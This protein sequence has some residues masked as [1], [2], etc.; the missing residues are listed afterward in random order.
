METSETVS[1]SSYGTPTSYP[2]HKNELTTYE[3][4]WYYDSNL[5]IPSNITMFSIGIGFMLLSFLSLLFKDAEDARKWRMFW[6]NGQFFLTVIFT[7]VLLWSRF[8]HLLSYEDYYTL[9]TTEDGED[10]WPGPKYFSATQVELVNAGCPYSANPTSGEVYPIR[11]GQKFPCRFLEQRFSANLMSRGEMKFAV[12]LGLIVLLVLSFGP[13]FLV[14]MALDDIKHE[15]EQIRS[16][17]EQE[18]PQFSWSLLKQP[19][20]LLRYLHY[21]A[22]KSFISGVE[23]GLLGAIQFAIVLL[24]ESQQFCSLMV[25]TN[26]I[27][28]PYC[29]VFFTPVSP[30]EAMCYYSYASHAVPHMIY[31]S[32]GLFGSWTVLKGLT[33]SQE[34]N[35][36]LSFITFV[37]T[38]AGIYCAIMFAAYFVYYFFAGFAIGIWF[39]FT[40]LGATLI[41]FLLEIFSVSGYTTHEL[42][43]KAIGP[44]VL[45]YF[46]RGGAALLLM[47][48]RIV[49]CLSGVN[50]IVPEDPSNLAVQMKSQVEAKA[51][52][53]VTEA[54]GQAET[55][56]KSA[57]NASLDKVNPRD[58][59]VAQLK[60]AI[61]ECGLHDQARD[62]LEKA[63]FVRLLEQH[64]TNC[65]KV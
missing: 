17:S 25:L 54:M 36:L 32:I 23:T 45:F 6:N 42:F 13:I 49:R 47:W 63:E 4:P 7:N 58:M 29:A 24:I 1:T 28:N 12:G 46:T 65:S 62:F 56:G 26:V 41:L 16:E 52:P 3:I 37:V 30:R 61:A 60:A 40:G 53:A 18:A 33:D 31:F 50:R 43:S 9:Q 5:L 11:S 21:A 22:K 35:A 59:S 27:V 15:R 39:E 14:K 34:N 51:T 2:T 10:V 55:L 8:A 44:C 19:V 57:A 38:L 48:A 20:E 64:Y